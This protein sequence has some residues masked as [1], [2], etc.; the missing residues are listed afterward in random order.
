LG[1]GRK[2]LSHSSIVRRRLWEEL[3]NLNGRVLLQALRLAARVV[4]RDSGVRVKHSWLRLDIR[5]L[6]AGILV[7]RLKHNRVLVSGL[8]R[9][10]VLVM[11]SLLSGAVVRLGIFLM[12]LGVSCLRLRRL[13]L[14]VLRCGVVSVVSSL[15]LILVLLRRLVEKQEEVD[16]PKDL[17]KIKNDIMKSNPK[18]KESMAYALATNILKR[19]KRKK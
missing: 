10:G 11:V 18:M 12:L 14:I 13:L 19:R 15:F 7:L 17:E 3:M 2:P 6:V 5:S 8:K 4:S 16:M 9:S 1:E